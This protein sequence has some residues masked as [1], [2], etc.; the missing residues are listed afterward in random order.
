[1]WSVGSLARW[2]VGLCL[3]VLLG[4]IQ[5]RMFALA[6]ITLFVICEDSVIRAFIT[7]FARI[8]LFAQIA[9]FNFGDS[10]SLFFDLL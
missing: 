8:P 1:M 10:L 2:L 3:A 9:L 7:L 4:C 5:S 6:R